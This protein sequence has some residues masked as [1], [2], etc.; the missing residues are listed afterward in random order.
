MNKIRLAAA[1]GPLAL[2]LSACG[3]SETGANNM[4]ADA[5]A[6]DSLGNDGGM[7]ND[8][9]GTNGSA[10]GGTS[11]SGASADGGTIVEENGI[12]YRVDAGGSRVRINGDGVVVDRPDVDVDLPK[13]NVGINEKGNPDVDVRGKADVD[14]R[15]DGNKSR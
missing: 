10:S 4:A 5:E 1:L 7:M 13:V 15:T 11:G 2:A 8:T 14:V 12:R 9:G 3:G 6:S